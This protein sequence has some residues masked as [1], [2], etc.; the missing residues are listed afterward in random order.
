MDLVGSNNDLGL[1]L[2]LEKILGMSHIKYKYFCILKQK[3]IFE[4]YQ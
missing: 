1:N 3:N 4:N 2:Q